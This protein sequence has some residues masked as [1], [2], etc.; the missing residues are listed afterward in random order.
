MD[1]I[2]SYIIFNN[3]VDKTPFSISDIANIRIVNRDFKKEISNKNFLKNALKK[4]YP[5]FFHNTENITDIL[6]NSEFNIVQLEKLFDNWNILTMRHYGE[7]YGY[8]LKNYFLKLPFK[9]DDITIEN[10]I[11]IFKAMYKYA[12]YK[13]RMQLYAPTD[14]S[15]YVSLWLSD[16][17]SV[18]FMQKYPYVILNGNHLVNM[19]NYNMKKLFDSSLNIYKLFESHILTLIDN[20]VEI[21]ASEES[22]MSLVNTIEIFLDIFARYQDNHDTME[23]LILYIM[24]YIHVHLLNI[25]DIDKSNEMYLTIKNKAQKLINDIP[26]NDESLVHQKLKAV[27]MQIINAMED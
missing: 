18:V 4:Q 21:I 8:R 20:E 10:N 19:T 9:T 5:M 22:F 26:E 1:S 27:C 24:R 14:I 7:K 11:K 15:K 13:M 23:K 3:V 16:Y 2:Q 17:C 12:E 25:T 6:L